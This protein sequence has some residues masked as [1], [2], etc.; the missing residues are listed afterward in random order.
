LFYKNSAVAILTDAFWHK[1]FNADPQV[2]GRKFLV[3]GMP[4]A[5]IGVLRPGFHFLSSQASS[6]LRP[7]PIRRIGASTGAIPTISPC[8]P[9]WPR[10]RR[11]R[12]RRRRS[13]RSTPATQGRPYADLLKRAG[14]HTT[15]YYLHADHVRDIRP[16]LLLLQG[17]VLFLLLIAVSISSTCS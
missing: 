3:D 4:V 8:S 7:R 12:M 13:T 9:G 16:I 11:W 15:V 14:Y 17:G 2:L 1:T 10:V 6:T 5:V